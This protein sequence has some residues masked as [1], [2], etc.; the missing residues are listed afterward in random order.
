MNEQHNTRGKVS[1]FSF[2]TVKRSWKVGKERKEKKTKV[3]NKTTE[4]RDRKIRSGI[5]K[6]LWFP[7]FLK[8]QTHHFHSI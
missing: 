7:S 5:N 4:L 2:I 8:Y 3:L 6:S 1:S